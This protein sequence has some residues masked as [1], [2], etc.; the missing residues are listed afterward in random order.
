MYHFCMSLA[1]VLGALSK[2]APEKKDIFGHLILFFNLVSSKDIFNEEAKKYV[3]A[4]DPYDM[5][6]LSCT[7]FTNA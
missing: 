5:Y 1:C 3:T 7:C 2:N 6:V 4:K